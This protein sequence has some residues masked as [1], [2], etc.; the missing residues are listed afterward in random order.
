MPVVLHLTLKKKWFD[1]I[2]SGKK[3]V[4]FREAKP[5]WQRR[6][7][8][9]GGALRQDFTEIHLRNGYSQ[10][11]PFMRVAFSHLCLYRSDFIHPEHGEELTAPHY[12]IIVL[13]EVLELRA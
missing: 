11:A 3:L 6:L 12:F 4:E 9:S 7:L 1:L 2:A 10:N 5:Y 13:G 8:D